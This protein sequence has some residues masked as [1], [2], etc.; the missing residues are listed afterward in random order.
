MLLD[1]RMEWKWALKCPSAVPMSRGGMIPHWFTDNPG[2]ARLKASQLGDDAR[3]LTK[4]EHRKEDV[5]FVFHGLRTPSVV[6]NHRQRE[7]EAV[8]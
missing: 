5:S 6:R 7:V 4:L 8:G 1:W 2:I 3:V